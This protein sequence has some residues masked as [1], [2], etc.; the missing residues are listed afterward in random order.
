MYDSALYYVFSLKEKDTYSKV[1]L[2]AGLAAAVTPTLGDVYSPQTNNA[3]VV[4]TQD[5]ILPNVWDV[6]ITQGTNCCALVWLDSDDTNDI[7]WT[8]TIF[9]NPDNFDDQVTLTIRDNQASVE[10]SSL[11]GV[12]EIIIDS[13]TNTYVDLRHLAI[14][15]SVGSTSSL[16]TIN[17]STM[18]AHE[19][20]GDLNANIVIDNQTNSLTDDLSV[21]IDGDVNRGGI[22]NNSGDITSVAV[23]TLGSGGDV[24]PVSGDAPE[25]WSIS[26]IGSVT[27]TGNFEGRIGSNSEGFLGSPDV[28]TIDVAGNFVGTSAMTVNSL[29]TLQVGGDF[30][31]DM[32]ISSATGSAGFYDIAGEIS[33]A[34]EISLPS[35]GLEGQ[36]IV[37]SGYTSDV[38]DGDVVVGSTTL[39]PN[40]TELSS[41]LGGGQVGVAPFNFHQRTTAPDTGQSKDCNPYHTEA[42]TAAYNP[43]T[44]KNDVIASVNIRHYGPVFADGAGSHF[45]VEFKSDVMPS[46]WVDRTSLFEID[47][48]VTGTSALTADRDAVIKG[49][50]FNVNG[51]TAAGVCCFRAGRV[52][53]M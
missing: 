50:V 48:S 46:S 21:E 43:S 7:I 17:A 33:S 47:T 12:E 31:A 19:V 38:W 34:A 2:A 28:S 27:V 44:G 29:N 20:G 13:P 1:V 5:P 45:R 26:S 4:I 10:K 30:D 25:F 6:E 15:G 51:F 40:Y 11:L 32:T 42:V 39:S 8:I 49:T 36:V 18:R 3:T 16:K 37:N 22:Y 35:D 24:A 14:E 53:L 52:R 9:N 41:E 23:G